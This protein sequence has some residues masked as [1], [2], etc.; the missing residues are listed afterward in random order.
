MLVS[1]LPNPMQTDHPNLKNLDLTGNKVTEQVN[2][3]KTIFSMFEKL[4][5]SKDMLTWSK[6]LDG[7]D[8]DG[9][10]VMSDVEDE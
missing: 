10:E 2:Y 3:T 4:E 1:T 5:V 7:Y 8:K 6:I 9:N